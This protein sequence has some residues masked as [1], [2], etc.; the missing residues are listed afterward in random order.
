MKHGQT[1]GMNRIHV[2]GVLAL[3]GLGIIFLLTLWIVASLTDVP[4]VNSIEYCKYGQDGRS[5]DFSFLV[6][7][8][9]P[10]QISA[11]LPIGKDSKP[12]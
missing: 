9:I 4:F 8:L 6:I 11:I 7:L 12:Y 1:E 2:I 10:N 5:G 3:T